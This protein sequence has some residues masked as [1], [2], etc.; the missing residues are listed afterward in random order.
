MFSPSDD[1]N[2][3]MVEGHSGPVTESCWFTEQG[4]QV[5]VSENLDVAGVII[6][7]EDLKWDALHCRNW[8]MAGS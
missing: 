7:E 3:W 4:E 8:F 5:G 1:K 6:L 2:Y